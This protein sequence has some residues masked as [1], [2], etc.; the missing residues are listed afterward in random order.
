MIDQKREFTESDIVYPKKSGKPERCPE[1]G[2]MVKM[3]CL[4]CQI[5]KLTES[6]KEKPR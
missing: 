5:R 6:K 1:C 2:G 3:P 4:G